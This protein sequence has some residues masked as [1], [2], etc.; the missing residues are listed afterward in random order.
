MVVM[1]LGYTFKKGSLYAKSGGE[2]TN[3]N[4]LVGNTIN[5]L[6]TIRAGAAKGATAL[7]SHQS[8]DAYA[9]K[10]YADNINNNILPMTEEEVGDII[11]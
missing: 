10:A 1:H 7:Q 8:L 9:T 3:I 4:V 2:L 11:G 6:D 5:D